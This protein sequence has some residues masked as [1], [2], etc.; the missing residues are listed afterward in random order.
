MAVRE[1]HHSRRGRAGV[2]RGGGRQVQNLM[3]QAMRAIEDAR[4]GATADPVDDPDTIAV[5]DAGDD[6]TEP[7]TALFD[8]LV[9][10]VQAAGEVATRLITLADVVRTSKPK[11]GQPHHAQTWT[12][13]QPNE[14]YIFRSSE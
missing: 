1:T 5:E 3:S 14:D 6:P 12:I 10:A 7:F 4:L 11:P 9:S 8:E 13:N 2:A